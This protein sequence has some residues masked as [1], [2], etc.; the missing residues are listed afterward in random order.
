MPVPPVLR[1][2][3]VFRA[4]MVTGVVMRR[5]IGVDVVG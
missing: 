3:R 4:F 1:A 2:A 5:S